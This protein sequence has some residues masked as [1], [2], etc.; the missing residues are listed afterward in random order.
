MPAKLHTMMPH[1]PYGQSTAAG[2]SFGLM[3]LKWRMETIVLMSITRLSVE[4][5]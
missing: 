2:P 3:T 4:R 1:C 5:E